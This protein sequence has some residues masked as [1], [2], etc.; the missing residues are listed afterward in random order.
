[1][2]RGPLF[3]VS[4]AVFCFVLGTVAVLVAFLVPARD[5]D[6]GLVP[7]IVGIVLLLVGCVAVVAARRRNKNP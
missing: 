3:L 4:Q 2:K 1:V 6:P 7:L 5:G